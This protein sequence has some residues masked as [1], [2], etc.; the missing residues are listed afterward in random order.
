VSWDERNQRVAGERARMCRAE[1]AR[2]VVGD[3][4]VLD[5]VEGLDIG[6][7]VVIC[8]ECVEHILDDRKLFCDVA[9]RTKPGGR[10]LLTTPYYYNHAIEKADQGPFST[11]ETGWHVRRGYTPAMLRE[12]CG[13]SGFTSCELTYCGGFLSQLATKIWRAAQRLP[14]GVGVTW[15]LTLPLRLIPAVLP[16]RL[17][18][19]CL[20]W[21]FSSICLEA[22]KPRFGAAATDGA[23]RPL[24]NDE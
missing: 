11:A 24:T 4:R 10:L 21:P 18:T 9:A 22:Y 13:Q 7:D 17:L 12:L 16:D 2:F 15:L 5:A 20:G 19:R 6:Y 14:G 23:T 8:L 1:Q 3:A